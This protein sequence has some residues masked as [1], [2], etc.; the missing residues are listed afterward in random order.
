MHPTFAWAIV[1]LVVSLSI[2]CTVALAFG[3]K[4]IST[5]RRQRFIN[6]ALPQFYNPYL[7]ESSKYERSWSP[8]SSNTKNFPG[9]IRKTRL[10]DKTSGDDYYPNMDAYQ[11]LEIPRT[12]DKKEIKAAYKRAVAKWHPDKFPDDENMKREGGLRMER[13]NRAYYCLG[14]DDRK[15]RYDTYGEQVFLK[16]ILL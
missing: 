3:S 15:R 4:I 1:F 13:I 2:T 6:A 10:Y 9:R 12:A 5:Q 11:V 7:E 16:F 8:F 14:D